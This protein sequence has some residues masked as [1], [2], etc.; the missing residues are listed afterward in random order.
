MRPSGKYA[1]LKV[2]ET[3]N[4]A[5]REEWSGMESPGRLRGDGLKKDPLRRDRMYRT[6]RRRMRLKIETKSWGS[7][8]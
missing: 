8:D 1:E 2:N 4:N 5:C 6:E 7:Q 3:L